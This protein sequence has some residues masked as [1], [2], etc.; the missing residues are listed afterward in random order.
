MVGS[1][2]FPH[3]LIFQPLV[4]VQS[5]VGVPGHEPELA[6]LGEGWAH[7]IAV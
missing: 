7:E 5:V 4:G 3:E 6:A 1:C 2:Y